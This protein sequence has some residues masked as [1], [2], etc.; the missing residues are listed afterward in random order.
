MDRCYH[1]AKPYDRE[2]IE[3][4]KL[5]YGWDAEHNE[6]LVVDEY[7][8]SVCGDPLDDAERRENDALGRANDKRECASCLR[9]FA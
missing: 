2:Q 6:E 9:T 7:A 3:E 4:I 1:G 8:C 5:M